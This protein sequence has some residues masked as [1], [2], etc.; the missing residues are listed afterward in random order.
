MLILHE[1]GWQRVI[2]QR[3]HPVGLL[4]CKEHGDAG[5]SLTSLFLLRI[6]VDYHSDTKL[7]PR[8][9]KGATRRSMQNNGGQ[10]QLLQERWELMVQRREV[11]ERYIDARFT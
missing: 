4:V 10:W 8:A 2:A 11:S 5:L 9:L 6:G 7:S 1:L 3:G